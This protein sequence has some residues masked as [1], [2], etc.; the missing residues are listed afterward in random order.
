VPLVGKVIVDWQ[1]MIDLLLQLED[2]LPEE[3]HD[4]Q[5]MYREAEQRRLDARK[6]AEEEL[7][8]AQRQAEDIKAD[9]REAA[10]RLVES[11]EIT[12]LAEER[13]QE[14]MRHADDYARQIRNEAEAYAAEVRRSA[15][16][17]DTNTRRSADEYA[18]T[19]LNHLKAVLSR[20]QA[21]VE[22]GLQQ[23]SKR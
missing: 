7:E 16:E 14:L 20:G 15:E 23:F 3:Y 18:A 21:S 12:R 1:M 22:D 17:Y 6:Q 11:D 5:R 19:L 13:S 4:A 10:A 9:A 2:A 8:R